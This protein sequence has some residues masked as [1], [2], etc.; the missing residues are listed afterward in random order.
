MDGVKEYCCGVVEGSDLINS[1]FING[2]LRFLDLINS[3]SRFSDLINSD[4]RFS[5]LI[6]SD[7]KFSD[8]INPNL[9]GC[10]LKFSILDVE[11]TPRA[12]LK[13]DLDIVG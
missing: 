3:D 9:V 5:D 6:N 13:Y 12:N 11:Q 8:L 4:S 1:C 10:E 7:S 2:D